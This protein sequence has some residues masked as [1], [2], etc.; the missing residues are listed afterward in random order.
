MFLGLPKEDV[1]AARKEYTQ[2]NIVSF[3]NNDVD[4]IAVTITGIRGGKDQSPVKYRLLVDL[5][6]FYDRPVVWVVDPP[7]E[8]IRHV[9]IWPHDFAD[10]HCQKLNKN[11]PNICLGTLK[12]DWAAQPQQNKTLL[13]FLNKIKSIL[14]KENFKSPARRS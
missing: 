10:C 2:L 1:L 7:D 12:D 6:R 11:L 4:L 14:S 3:K 9:N 13:G 8:T 5:D